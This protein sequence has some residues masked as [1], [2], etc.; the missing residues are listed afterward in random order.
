[1]PETDATL[2]LLRV[3]ADVG[4]T[5][6]DRRAVRD[7]VQAAVAAELESDIGGGAGQRGRPVRARWRTVGGALALGLSVVVVIV[8]TVGA[9]A[10]ISHRAG[11]SSAPAAPSS[12]PGARALIAKLAVLRRPQTAADRLPNGV[13][14]TSSQGTLVPRLTRLVGTYPHN[15]F[16]LVVLKPAASPDSL[17]P[18]RYGDQVAV[19]DVLRN[20]AGALV[21]PK[22]ISVSIPVPAADLDNARQVSLLGTY[23]A[24]MR[25]PNV[26]AVSIVRDGVAR[27]R[28]SFS[29][30]S[31]GSDRGATTLPV[32]DNAVVQ[33]LTHDQ[34]SVDRSTWYGA[35]GRV[36]PTSSRT[37]T[38]VLA[39]FRARLRAI[40][41]R[42]ARRTDYVAPRTLLSAFAVFG[43]DSRTGAQVAPGVTVSWPRL[44][45]LPISV[46]QD[47]LG[48]GSIE[49]D[50]RQVR[51][52]TFG[53]G[54]RLW[55]IPGAK[56]MA[57]ASGF[58]ASAAGGVVD[59]ARQ[60]V[61]F[62]DVGPDGRGTRVGVVSKTTTS[63][64]VN[65][66]GVRHTFDP[67]SGVYA[68]QGGKLYH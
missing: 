13:R 34:V 45:A 63:V 59:A 55:V 60:G 20:D 67:A 4:V 46:L 14:V 44:S 6:P 29:G 3:L 15:R 37:A 61:G 53:G 2:E 22:H 64:T 33:R 24:S 66:G 11:G 47:Q 1:M 68:V 30:P 43:V 58:G 52:V 48:R 19:V 50:F 27:V 65:V 18:A 39:V 23:V 42:A 12:G 25:S 17:W 56:G 9:V 28:W 49:P 21:N 7:R 5:P 10:L 36:V 54:P 31:Y 38:H 16:Y 62:S 35:D 26:W 32:R 57:V 41:L 8:V 40:A 51:E